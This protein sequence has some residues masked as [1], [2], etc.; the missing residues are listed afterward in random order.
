MSSFIEVKAIGWSGGE[1]FELAMVARMSYGKNPFELSEA[2]AELWSEEQISEETR[3]ERIRAFN[4][5]S[6]KT[7]ETCFKCGHL[8][9][10]EFAEITYWIHCPIYVARQLMRYRNASY[11]E[12]SLRRCAPLPPDEGQDEE[13]NELY[14]NSLTSY[15]FLHDTSKKKKKELARA[16][17]TLA[18]P[19]EFLMK[20]D[21]RE[22]FHIFD[23][24]LSKE[25]QSETRECVLQMYKQFEEYNPDIAEMYRKKR[26]LQGDDFLGTKSFSKPDGDAIASVD[27][28][29]DDYGN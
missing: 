29:V 21:F 2:Y 5:A 1:T 7:V 23:E 4:K 24:R 10:F 15:I 16:A 18:A 26:E 3:D 20:V 6:L 17:L 14:A 9:V 25:A 27:A 12:R 28:G 13:I 11:I 19:T 8:S 22:L